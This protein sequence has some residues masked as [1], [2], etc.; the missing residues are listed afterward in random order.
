ML[1]NVNPTTTKAWKALEEHFAQTKGRTLKELFAADPKRFEEFSLSVGD[2][3]IVVD[4]SKNLIDKKTLSLLLDLA[5]ECDVK[6]DIVAMFK[7]D[8]I[9]R[10]EDRAVLH[11]A[12]RNF[13]GEPV[14][15][16]GADVMV[17]V[18]AVLAKMKSFCE[19]VI[20]G[21]W[22]GYTGKPI[23]D[24]VNIG[25]G[26]SD[27]GPCMITEAL[28]PYHNHLKSHLILNRL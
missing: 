16:D 5:N 10:T 25:I 28:T 23:T 21:E 19:R 17:D 8:K 4:Y 26:G 12:L 2:G 27:L 7:G 13:S 1:K 20:S 18:K 11:T 9:N 22:K 6:D 14:M 24:V 15:L 3:D